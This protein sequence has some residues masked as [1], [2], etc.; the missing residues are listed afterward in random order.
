MPY[1]EREAAAL[2][3]QIVLAVAHCHE[4]NVMH[5]DLK[6]E[7]V[8]LRA[9]PRVFVSACPRLAPPSSCPLSPPLAL[10]CWHR[11]DPRSL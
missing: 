11:H 2:F 9:C 3:R 7:N 10:F 4:R 5:R 6:P 8:R 1:S